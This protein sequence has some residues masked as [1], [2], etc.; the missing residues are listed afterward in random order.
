MG[1]IEFGGMQQVM[2]EGKASELGR[3]TIA[4]ITRYRVTGRLKMQANL[5]GTPGKRARLNQGRVFV[6]FLNLEVSLHELDPEA[7]ISNG[8]SYGLTWVDAKQAVGATAMACARLPCCQLRNTGRQCQV[9]FSER[10]FQKCS[11]ERRV[12][13]R[14]FAEDQH[15]RCVTIKLVRKMQWSIGTVAGRQKLARGP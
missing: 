2:G 4:D 5:V 14:I 9:A 6:Y 12:C 8:A 15:T 10:A 13:A 3:S 1:Q 11:L 7:S